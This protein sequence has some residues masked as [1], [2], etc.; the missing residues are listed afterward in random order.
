MPPPPH[1]WWCSPTRPQADGRSI[2]D[3]QQLTIMNL[4]RNKFK[5]VTSDLAK[6]QNL[7]EV[8]LSENRCGTVL[9]HY[10]LRDR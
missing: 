10:Q 7:N 3:L 6:C 1:A 5:R 9:G 8:D 4:S 2:A